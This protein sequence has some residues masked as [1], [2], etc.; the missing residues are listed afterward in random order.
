[1]LPNKR[2]FKSR[3]C[4]MVRWSSNPM[5]STENN[6]LAKSCNWFKASSFLAMEFKEAASLR[7]YQ[8][9]SN[10]DS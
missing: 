8:C 4:Q 6:R 2:L 1:M 3:R 5:I 7:E 10:H 9:R